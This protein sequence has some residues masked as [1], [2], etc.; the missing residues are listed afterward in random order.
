MNAE[1]KLRQR[2]RRMLV[3]AGANRI[4]PRSVLEEVEDQA[5]QLLDEFIEA[6][7]AD[8]DEV[9]EQGEKRILETLS[10]ERTLYAGVTRTRSHS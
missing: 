2:I 9:Y 3:E 5:L 8:E 6:D 1:Q 4:Q 7:E 10:G